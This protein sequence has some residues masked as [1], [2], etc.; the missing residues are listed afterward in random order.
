MPR[1]EVEDHEI[2]LIE[3]RYFNG[4][5]AVQMAANILGIDVSISAIYTQK[6][7]RNTE[8]TY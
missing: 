7:Y 1:R 4:E 6:Q 3:R 8:Y 5:R 2:F